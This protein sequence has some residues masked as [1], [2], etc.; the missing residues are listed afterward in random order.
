MLEKWDLWGWLRETGLSPSVKYFT[1][2]SKAVLLLWIIHVIS[3]VCY[4]FVR[5]CLLMPSGRRL[6]NGW[7]LGSRLWC[8]IVSLLLS[9][10]YFGSGVVLDCID[11][12]SLPSFLLIFCDK[13][14]LLM[15][16]AHWPFCPLTK[17]SAFLLCI[18]STALFLEVAFFHHHSQL[19]KSRN[20]KIY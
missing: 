4:A 10:W 9:H 19:L 20:L 3:C 2:Q 17:R 11:S 15:S 18:T 12:W 16:Q 5:V 7:P 1:D 13:H 6:G 8:L 14:P